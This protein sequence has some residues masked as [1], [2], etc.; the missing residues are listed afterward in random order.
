MNNAKS[1]QHRDRAVRSV[2]WLFFDELHHEVVDNLRNV[3][4]QFAR[5]FWRLRDDLHKDFLNR[6]ARKR[7]LTR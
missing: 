6:L 3:I 1:V 7:L 5:T 2:G 4:L